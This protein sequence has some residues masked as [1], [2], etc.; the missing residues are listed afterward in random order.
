MTKIILNERKARVDR[1]AQR[2][3]FPFHS[4]SFKTGHQSPVPAMDEGQVGVGDTEMFEV[5]ESSVLRTFPTQ[6]QPLVEFAHGTAGERSCIDTA[7]V[8]V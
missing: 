4:R 1:A 5:N 8:W 2:L 6:K 7:V 3:Q